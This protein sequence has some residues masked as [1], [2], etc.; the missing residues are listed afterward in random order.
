M[1]HEERISVIISHYLVKFC[2]HRR[3]RRGDVLFLI[4]VAT[5]S[6]AF[7]ALWVSVSHPKSPPR[8]SYFSF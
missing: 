8:R 1:L 6:M 5:W 4:G 2:G 3:S 7:A